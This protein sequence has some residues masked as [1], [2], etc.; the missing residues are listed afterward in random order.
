MTAKTMR[1]M[2]AIAKAYSKDPGGYVAT[3][4]N[5]QLLSDL[6]GHIKDPLGVL[7]GLDLFRRLYGNT[8]LHDY[9]KGGDFSSGDPMMSTDHP[10]FRM[11]AC[12]SVSCKYLSQQNPDVFAIM[13]REMHFRNESGGETSAEMDVLKRAGFAPFKVLTGGA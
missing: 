13:R 2:H 12:I 9:A 11:T 10:M 4:P 3:P 5:N 8:S 1:E 7:Q 6:V